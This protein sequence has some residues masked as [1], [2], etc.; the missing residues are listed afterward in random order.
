MVDNL[1]GEVSKSQSNKSR[2]QHNPVF[3]EQQMDSPEMEGESDVEH[4]R[5]PTAASPAPRS[6]H[7]NFKT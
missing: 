4:E 7:L 2:G 1:I 6:R 3:L 5:I